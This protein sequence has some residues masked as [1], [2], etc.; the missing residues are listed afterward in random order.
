MH[1]IRSAVRAVSRVQRQASATSSSGETLPTR[2]FGGG[3][4]H[5]PSGLFNL[6]LARA[7]SATPRLPP[8]ATAASARYVCTAFLAIALAS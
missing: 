7:H 3:G 5:F 4:L 8:E 2:A 6:A 1:D